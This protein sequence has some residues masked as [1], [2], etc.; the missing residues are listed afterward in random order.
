ESRGGLISLAVF[1]L[2]YFSF[3]EKKLPVFILIA[4]FIVLLFQFLPDGFIDRF[5]EI[6]TSKRITE[7]W[8]A[9]LRALEDNLVVGTGLGTNRVVIPRYFGYATFLDHTMNV[10]NSLLAVGV[11]LGL[12]GL[13]LYLSF[14]GIPTRNL[15][16]D[17]K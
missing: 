5:Q 8:P 7:L 6:G 4:F 15:F 16:C 17:I 9:G 10:H 12:P 14:V 13:I 11:E 2:L 3:S 1:S